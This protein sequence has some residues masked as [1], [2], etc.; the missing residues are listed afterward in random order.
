MTSFNIHGRG[1]LVFVAAMTALPPLAIDMALPSL[2][3]VQ[4]DFGA[5]QTRAAATIAIF[6]A[7]FSTAPLRSARSPTASAASP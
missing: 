1:F 4:A 6:L 2:A 5:T 7:G 3:L